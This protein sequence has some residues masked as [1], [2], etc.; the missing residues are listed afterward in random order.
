MNFAQP[1]KPL[2]FASLLQS[3]GLIQVRK[4]SIC[5]RL[6]IRTNHDLAITLVIL[7][8]QKMWEQLKPHI[9]KNHSVWP[10]NCVKMK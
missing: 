7:K 10:Y 4:Y 9:C 8:V 1:Q 6:F 3:L 5:I 2:V